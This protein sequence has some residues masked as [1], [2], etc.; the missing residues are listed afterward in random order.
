MTWTC[1]VGAVS[2]FAFA[3][4]AGAVSFCA[5]PAFTRHTKTASNMIAMLLRVDGKILFRSGAKG[6]K[7][8]AAPGLV[9]ILC[10]D[11]HSA[12]IGI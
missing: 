6:V 4:F 1:S 10:T 12:A 11:E 2:F 3:G 9:G 8:R 7:V 5:F